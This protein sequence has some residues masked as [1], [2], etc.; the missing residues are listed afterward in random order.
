[1]AE[2]KVH[3]FQE[4]HYGNFS[5]EVGLTVTLEFLPR[6]GDYCTILFPAIAGEASSVSY[7]HASQHFVVVLSKFKNVDV[8]TPKFFDSR[9]FISEGYDQTD[10]AVVITDGD[11]HLVHAPD[12][13]EP[14]DSSKFD[15]IFAD[16]LRWQKEQ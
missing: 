16:K 12:R 7:Y 2:F 10:W 5:V 9:H 1:M 13:D 4:H 3:F 11:R 8:L 15:K 6:T 14:F